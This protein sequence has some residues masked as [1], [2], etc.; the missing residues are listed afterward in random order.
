MKSCHF[1][2]C[3]V[4]LVEERRYNFIGDNHTSNWF[5][6]CGCGYRSEM[7]DTAEEAV[8][9]HDRIPSWTGDEE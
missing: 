8:K 3:D 7:F 5:V 6:D 2:H 4:Y 1:C 9:A